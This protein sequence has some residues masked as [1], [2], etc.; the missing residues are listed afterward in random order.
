[1]SISLSDLQGKWARHITPMRFHLAI[2][3][4][5]IEG[6]GVMCPLGVVLVAA[7]VGILMALVLG[8][9]EWAS[10]IFW[11]RWEKSNER[12][13]KPESPCA[14]TK[15]KRGNHLGHAQSRRRSL[16]SHRH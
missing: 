8:G 11:P 9:N 1:M 15:R 16:A 6:F 10:E 13:R 14:G 2:F 5:G 7:P 12:E 3:R 4:R